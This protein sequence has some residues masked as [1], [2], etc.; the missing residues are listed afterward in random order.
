M[1]RWARPSCNCVFIVQG[2]R[3]A[4]GCTVVA[5]VVGCT[6]VAVVVGGSMVVRAEPRNSCPAG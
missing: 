5:V 1:M 3:V 2:C 4:E 6:V